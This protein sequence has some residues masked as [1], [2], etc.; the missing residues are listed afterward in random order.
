MSFHIFLLS[1][2]K[3][4]VPQLSRLPLVSSGTDYFNQLL[5]IQFDHTLCLTIYIIRICPFFCNIFIP[6]HS[7][8]FDVAHYLSFLISLISFALY[9]F[10]FNVTV[11]HWF[12]LLFAL[13]NFLCAAVSYRSCYATDFPDSLCYGITGLKYVLRDVPV[14]QFCYGYPDSFLG[15]T[16]PHRSQPLLLRYIQTP[17]CC[18]VL[19]D[20]SSLCYGFSR[21]FYA[22]E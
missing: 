14:S 9:I 8:H 13:S 12:R 21:L 3:S 2:K 19:P 15:A 11:P 22:M 5:A 20:S 4:V 16:V 17:W 1:S 10:F 18:G 7:V 6:F